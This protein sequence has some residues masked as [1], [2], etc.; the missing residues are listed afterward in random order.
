M[1]QILSSSSKFHIDTTTY[2][3]INFV[4]TLVFYVNLFTSAAYLTV[5]IV[6]YHKTFFI[7]SR[8]RSNLLSTHPIKNYFVYPFTCSINYVFTYP[9]N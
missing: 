6:I 9:S 2:Y 8:Y 1:L 7:T 3:K 5:V 4:T